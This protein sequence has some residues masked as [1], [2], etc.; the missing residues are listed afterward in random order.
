MKQKTLLFSVILCFLLAILAISWLVN[1]WEQNAKPGFAQ[2]VFIVGVLLGM[3]IELIIIR[4]D[5][6][7][8]K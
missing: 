1:T 3:V 8:Q 5:K 2:V 4:I 7:L 6:Q